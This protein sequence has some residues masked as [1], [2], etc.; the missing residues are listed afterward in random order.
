LV[1]VPVAKVR[2]EEIYNE[3]TIPAEFRPYAEDELHAKVAG[4]VE[5]ITVDFG[6]RVK[7]GQLLAKL[8]VPELKAELDRAIASQKRAQ[9]DYQDA[10]LSY[11]RLLAVDK[12]HTNLVAQQEIDTAEARD[13]TTEAA[14]DAAKADV[15]RYQTMVAYTRITAPFDGI[16][17]KRYVDPGAL[18]QAGTASQTQSLPIVRVS[19]IHRL[20][21]DFPVSVPN[22][23]D[24]NVGDSVEV[25]VD[26][27]GGQLI[28]GVISRF[29]H[30]IDEATRTM[31]TEVEVDN[32]DFKLVPGMYATVMLRVDRQPDSLSVPTEALSADR[33]G[34]LYVVDQDQTVQERAVTLGVETPTKCQILAG[35][36]EGDLV[37]LGSRSLA[38][39]GQ[40][41]APKLDS[42]ARR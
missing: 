17:T 10:H 38:R 24:I 26:S 19:D 33:K 30:Q 20:R 29:S 4:Y 8:E 23:K 42:L 9:A 18:I 2:R 3:L 21:L 5:S 11:T 27:L 32:P 35:L 1:T 28:K 16:V 31:M 7:A 14:V 36:Q 13:H 40:K 34:P 22:V 25:R 39:P 15:E 12:A 6:D 41:V 37:L